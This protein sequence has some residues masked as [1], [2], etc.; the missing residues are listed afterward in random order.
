[1]TQMTLRA[2]ARKLREIPLFLR[3]NFL[4]STQPARSPTLGYVA[5]TGSSQI[6]PYQIV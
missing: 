4:F 3:V 5:P 2:S 6:T 1:M